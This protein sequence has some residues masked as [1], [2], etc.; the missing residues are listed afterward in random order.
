MDLV[1]HRRL[2]NRKGSDDDMGRW[3]TIL[4]YTVSEELSATDTYHEVMNVDATFFQKMQNAKKIIIAIMFKAPS[5]KTSDALGDIK[6][7]LYSQR[8]WYPFTFIDGNYLPN[9]TSGFASQS[10]YYK[11]IDLTNI[12]ELGHNDM[13][14]VYAPSVFRLKG[15]NLKKIDEL[16]SYAN[17]YNE[18]TILRVINKKVHVGKGSRI[19]VLV[20][21]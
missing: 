2:L 11:E 9:L 5:V 20:M 19:R 7:S 18:Q 17:M 13:I 16:Y 12:S 4:D 14:G 1:E 3:E 15:S 21:S 8:G 6:I 10:S